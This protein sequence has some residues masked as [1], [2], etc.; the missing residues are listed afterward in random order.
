MDALFEK[1]IEGEH[2]EAMIKA[3]NQGIDELAILTEKRSTKSSKSLRS[4]LSHLPQERIDL[5]R[6]SFD[7]QTFHP[8]VDQERKTCDFLKDGLSVMP[9]VS[10][11]T[12]DGLLKANKYIQASIVVECVVFALNLVG[13]SPPQK[14][15]LKAV[16][17]AWQYDELV[18]KN[19]E[20]LFDE[21][22]KAYLD[23]DL[24]GLALLVLKVIMVVFGGLLFNVIVS[25]L[26][27][28]MSWLDWVIFSA[29]LTAFV[30]ALIFTGGTAV[31]VEI[32]VLV[33][34]AA[35]F[36]RKFI[37]LAEAV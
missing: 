9:T 34:D 26:L 19:L 27:S 10:I 16:D 23:D 20:P 29:K 36:L 11:D 24:P 28:T 14:V 31:V 22:K 15:V 18:F 4:Y 17:L 32:I 6:H 30:A 7:I 35:G 37:D 12:T 8:S 33:I 3:I 2:R 21:M 25:A 1:K 5:I 13:F